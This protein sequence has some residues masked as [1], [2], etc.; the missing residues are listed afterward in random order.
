MIT[1]TEEEA[2][3]LTE[4]HLEERREAYEDISCPL[5]VEDF[6]KWLYEKGFRILK[7]KEKEVKKDES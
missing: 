4:Q 3:E 7:D 2:K 5:A 1:C 6:V